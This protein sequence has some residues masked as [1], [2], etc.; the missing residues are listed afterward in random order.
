MMANTLLK[1]TIAVRLKLSVTNVS[2]RCADLN[3]PNPHSSKVH[4]LKLTDN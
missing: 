3:K 4:V 2:L 1:V